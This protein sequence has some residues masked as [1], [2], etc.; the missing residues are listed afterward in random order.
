MAVNRVADHLRRCHSGITRW[1]APEPDGDGRVARRS[2]RQ[3]VAGRA[4]HPRRTV[5]DAAYRLLAL[6]TTSFPVQSSA[7]ALAGYLQAS[8]RCPRNDCIDRVQP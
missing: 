3:L 6:W 2:A 7:D 1:R 8:D 5:V 4:V